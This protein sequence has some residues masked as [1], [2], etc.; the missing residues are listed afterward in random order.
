MC[1][2]ASRLKDC[3]VES[4]E[5]RVRSEA[6]VQERGVPTRNALKTYS[7]ETQCFRLPDL[8]I[9]Y[10]PEIVAHAEFCVTRS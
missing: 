7:R 1:T 8:G 10:V 6:T 2:W 9:S 4:V 3:F 5:H